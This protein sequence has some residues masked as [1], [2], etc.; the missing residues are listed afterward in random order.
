MAQQRTIMKKSLKKKTSYSNHQ[1]GEI[2]F[3]PTL[4]Q[5]R[6]ITMQIS[7]RKK[8]NVS[9]SLHQM[10]FIKNTILDQIY[11]NDGEIIEGDYQK[12]MDLDLSIPA[13]VDGWAWVLVKDG[14]IDKEIELLTERKKAFEDMIYKMKSAKERLKV[15]LNDI[16]MQYGLERIDGNNFWIKRNVSTSS[17]VILSKVEDELKSYELPKLSFSE[18][19]LI[20]QSIDNFNSNLETDD[21]I[22][23]RLREKIKEEVI[24]TCG[25]KSLPDGHIAIESTETPTV[26]ISPIKKSPF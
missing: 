25:V 18:Y 16:L 26:R 20:R 24:Q 1:S 15:R 10:L 4:K 6:G 14:V 7:Q 11:D 13:K 12:L 3:S 22:V 9:E 8:S 17:K 21:L 2:N 19:D 5:M 23:I